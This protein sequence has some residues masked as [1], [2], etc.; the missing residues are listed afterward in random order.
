[1]IFCESDEISFETNF[2]IK[3]LSKNEFFEI[4]DG[5]LKLSLSP[6]ISL[7]TNFKTVVEVENKANNYIDFFTKI[8]SLRD[9]NYLKADLNNF[10]T[11]N[12]DKT[13][14]VK[15]YNYRSSG[16]VLDMSFIFSKP[17][18]NTV[19]TEFDLSLIF[20]I[21]DLFKSFDD[22]IKKRT[23]KSTVEKLF[24]GIQ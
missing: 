10:I 6:E 15:K 3:V 24:M 20:L 7:Q 18:E 22:V 23:D 19:V 13:Y 8:E 4:Y 17:F 1:M 11:L 12:F 5:D 2:S 16:K 9:I 14:K 21:F